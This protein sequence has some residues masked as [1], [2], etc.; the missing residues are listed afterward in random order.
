MYIFVLHSEEWSS[1]FWPRDVKGLSAE[2]LLIQPTHYTGEPGY[3]TDTEESDLIP[4]PQM[5]DNEEFDTLADHLT[6]RREMRDITEGK[7]EL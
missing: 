3:I 4:G 5:G 2:P 1:H 6:D 7:D